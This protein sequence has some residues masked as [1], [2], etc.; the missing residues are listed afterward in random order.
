MK[1]ETLGPLTAQVDG[2]GFVPSA[3]KP[4]Q[5]LAL[6]A[7]QGGRV[8]PVPVLMEEVWGENPPRS[9][10]ATLQTYVLQLRRRI[11]EA[12]GGRSDR[13]PKDVLVTVHG[14]YLLDV[15]P[16][17]VDAQ[18]F[19]RLLGMGR[20][21]LHAGEDHVAAQLLDRALALWRGPAL[22]D[23]Q[24]GR[25]LD[26]EVLRL[27]EARLGALENRIGAD[28]RLG[29]H[30]DVI[31]ELAVLAARYPMHEGFH[32]QLM[33]AQYRAGRTWQALVT[34]QTLRHTL[35]SE[36]G[37]GPSERIRQL[38]QAVLASRLPMSGG[39]GERPTVWDRLAG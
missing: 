39:W 16:G 1:I 30:V 13:D 31:G 5:M 22:V 11:S 35:D 38:H 7:L 3:A 20:T 9:A 12:L 26:I 19:D 18:E 25:L 34:Y 36:L 15:A 6:L 29:R 2:A 4:R 28:L 17:E 33:V 10:T 21:A 14:G 37:I 8:V 23:V 32:E 24:R 27:D